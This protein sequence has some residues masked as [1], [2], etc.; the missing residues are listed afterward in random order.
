MI[1]RN[2][3]TPLNLLWL[4]LPA[5][6]SFVGLELSTEILSKTKVTMV[7]IFSLVLVPLDIGPLLSV[8]QGP[9]LSHGSC[10]PTTS[11]C[12]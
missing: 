4:L 5:A 9:L 2:P 7:T 11:A 6:K 3:A 8:E 10:F 12:M 1:D